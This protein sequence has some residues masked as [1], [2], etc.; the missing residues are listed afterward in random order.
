MD[1]V[2]EGPD[3][4]DAEEA[5][6]IRLLGKLAGQWAADAAWPAGGARG[7]VHDP[8]ER[9]VGGYGAGLSV[10]ELGVR[11]ETG[12]RADRVTVS[13]GQLRLVRGGGRGRREPLVGDE[14]PGAR[15]GD[16]PGDLGADEVV[17][18]RDEVQTGLGGGEVRGEELDPVG[19]HDGEGVALLQSCR[20]QPVNEL[21]DGGVQASGGPCLAVRRDQDRTIRVGG[22]LGPEA[23][24]RPRP[25]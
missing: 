17:V 11:A 12:D 13:D 7:V 3:A 21:V 8:A 2:V 24:P 4:E 10:E 22:R 19:Q 25:G 23:S 16:D 5:A 6:E 14:H 18:D 9:A 1:V 15:V 20:A